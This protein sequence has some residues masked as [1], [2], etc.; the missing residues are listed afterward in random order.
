MP[1]QNVSRVNRSQPRTRWYHGPAAPNRT[2][3][4]GGITGCAPGLVLAI[5]RTV[6]AT[7]AS[8]RVAM[9]TSHAPWSAHA[10]HVSMRNCGVIVL[11]ASRRVPRAANSL[12]ASGWCGATP[13]ATRRPTRTP[14]RT[15]TRAALMTGRYPFQAE[16]PDE[17]MRE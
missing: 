1:S 9:R 2:G 3:S 14:T 11:A 10:R 16:D 17:V 4:T 13:T 15:P 5:Q 7:G 6:S 12:V 8:Q